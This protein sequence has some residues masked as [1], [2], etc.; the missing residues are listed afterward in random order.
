MAQLLDA[1]GELHLSPWLHDQLDSIS[2]STVRRILSRYHPTFRHLPRKRP[3]RPRP[4]TK[5]IPMRRIPWDTPQ[6]DHFEVDLVHLCDPTSSGHYVHSLQM[7]DVATGWSERRAILGRTWLV[8]RD[9]FRHVLHHLPFAVREI[10]SDNGS[11]FLNA[12]LLRFW[13]EA[14]SHITLS[15]SRP[16]Q[17][18]DNRFV[19]QKNSSLIRAYLGHERLDTVAQTHL[20]NQLYDKMDCYYNLFL[21]VMHLSEKMLI[22]ATDDQPARVRRRYDPSHTPFDRLCDTDAI[23]DSYR[24]HFVELRQSINPRKLR[25]EI[26]ELRDELFSLPN[27]L[28]DVSENAHHTLHYPHE[29]GV[30]TEHSEQG[31]VMDLPNG[32]TVNEPANPSLWRQGCANKSKAHHTISPLKGG[33]SPW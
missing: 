14:A 28:A 30:D 24:Q 2:T 26:Y 22:P 4:L 32:L 11:E 6:P 16:Y 13:A 10:H 7:V 21:P 25:E 3:S 29:M 19:E 31:E 9:A 20:L 8:M 17:K 15:R 23:T 5:G 1:H 33:D 27:A 12:H 18:N